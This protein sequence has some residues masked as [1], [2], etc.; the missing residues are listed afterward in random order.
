MIT[1]KSFTSLEQSKKLAEIL[2][3]E[4]A[5]MVLP[6]KHSKNDE[7]IPGYVVSRNYVE[8]YNEMMKLQ[9]MEKEDVCK[10]IQP[11]WSLAALL[12]QIT[13]EVCDDDGNSSYL[14]MNKDNEEHFSIKL[15]N[16]GDKDY[17]VNVGD[18]IGQG[19]FVKYLT[20]DDEE[21]IETKRKGGIGST[22]K[23]EEK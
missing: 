10:L 1:I 7:Y 5:D 3:I 9:R 20:V 11:C 16:H 21:K 18:R 13:Y 12:E 15:I 4:S 2:P 19:I 17:V 8:V 6:F 22:N 14:Q 23:K